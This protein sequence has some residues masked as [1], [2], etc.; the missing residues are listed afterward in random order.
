[1]TVH[2]ISVEK[3]YLDLVEALNNSGF[4]VDWL[5]RAG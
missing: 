4:E 3:I 5:D 1:M 2:Y